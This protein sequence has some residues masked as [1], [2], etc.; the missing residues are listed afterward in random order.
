MKGL[1]SILAT[2]FL[3]L[4]SCEQLTG[5]EGPQGEPGPSY[6]I[7]SHFYIRGSVWELDEGPEYFGIFFDAGAAN[8]LVE[9]FELSNTS[10]Y[11]ILITADYGVPNQITVDAG[12]NS[13]TQIFLIESAGSFTD[14]DALPSSS[15]SR[16]EITFPQGETRFFMVK[17][18][19]DRWAKVRISSHSWDHNYYDWTNYDHYVYRF[20]FEF[21]YYKDEEP[22]L[23]LHR[24][25][26]KQD[27]A[28]RP[29]G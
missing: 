29:S 23:T 11:D 17:N 13:D 25:A 24:F 12:Y 18:R 15:Q 21:Y 7:H 6:P 2:V 10:L 14:I 3:I 26:S 19:Y 4:T 1:R 16:A 9:T 28:P 20:L 27:S 22:D 5:P 8:Y